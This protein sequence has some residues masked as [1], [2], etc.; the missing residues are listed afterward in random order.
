MDHQT[1]PYRTPVNPLIEAFVRWTSGT[2]RGQRFGHWLGRAL[3]V[4]ELRHLTSDDVPWSPLQRPIREATVALVTTSGVHL[5]ADQPF[6]LDGADCSFRVIPCTAEPG[7]LAISHR[8]YDRSDALRDINL[9]F[10][11]QRLRELEAEGVIGRVAERHYTFGLV[12]VGHAAELI[13]PGREVGRLLKQ[14]W[15]DLALFVPA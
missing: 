11:L 4:P 12:E 5:R 1:T 6:D 13:A 3:A 7:D 9:V 8:A 2:G 10:P 14:D 15:V